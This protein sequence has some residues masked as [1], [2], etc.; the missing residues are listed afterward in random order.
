MFK[1]A[2]RRSE[3]NKV[4]AVFK[5]HFHV[6]Q[7][8]QLNVDA[9]VMSVVPGGVGKPTARLEKGIL[10]EGSCRWE[11]PIYE[12]V[13]FA[14]DARTGKI[15]ERTYHFIVSTGSSKNSLV[16]EVSIDL[17]N[18]AEATK[19][20]T[21]S[22]PLR[23]SKSNGVLHVSI[24]RLQGGIDQRDVEETDNTDIQTQNRTLNAHLSNG[25]EEGSKSNSNEVGPLH[26]AIHMSD[27]NGDRRTSSGSDITMSS[28]ESSSGVNTPWELGSRNNYILQDSTSFPS[29][30]SHAS[31]PHKP[32]A[33]V[34]AKIYEENRQS[35]WEWSAD[36]DH[37]ICIDD[38]ISGSLD[39]LTAERSQHNSDIEIE[40]L[41]DEIV[42]LAR[43]IDL[44]EL[45]LQTLRK[46]IVKESKRGQ[47]LSRE[48][49]S[50][51]EER[52]VLKAECEKLKAFQ[53]QQ[54]IIDLSSEIEIYRRDKDEL[55]M[56]MEQLA[57]DY[58]ILKQ[59]N[60]DMSYKLEQSQLQDQLM[61]Q[62]ECSSFAN[63]N[64]L[65][66]QIESLENELQKQSK[67]YSESLATIN[68]LQ[69]YIK[70]L[71]DEL[72]KQAEGFEADL[73]AVTCG[74][75]EQEQR[76]IRAEEALRKTRWKNANTAE[77]LQEE[78]KKLSMQMAST[79]DANE[80]VAIKSLAEANDLR[81]K[82]SQL[83]EMLQKANEDLHSVRD[84]YETKL[85]YLSSQLNFKMDQI[86]Q[87]LVEIDDKRKQLEHKKNMRRNL[88]DLSHKKSLG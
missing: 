78:F 79:F 64:E 33:N 17:A 40:K 53:K 88:L 84:D 16:G 87:M 81:M 55:E 80:K 49:M 41:K 3:K 73:E 65:E 9:L 58:E 14:Q 54:R 26:D 32:I 60:H 46:Q 25:E 56:Q 4:K 69:T 83:E 31:V 15:D 30:Q 48:V 6:T 18:Y 29:S 34:S 36:S 7:V 10:R 74:K 28:S 12:T 82:K 75:V 38:S 85:C 62:Y 11:Y 52:H 76:A 27:V 20:S 21:V 1:S 24:Q 50:L 61:L 71:E 86:E 13:K 8:F 5:F 43:Q 57:L 42:S 44:S 72:E 59:E 67:A 77:K 66:A 23:N 51:K 19:A 47:D 63:I 2:R 68:E 39:N 37:G 45:E 70:S 35:Q 22:L